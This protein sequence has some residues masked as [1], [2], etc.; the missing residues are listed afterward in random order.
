M[1]AAGRTAPRRKAS[2]GDTDGK[3]RP[4]SEVTTMALSSA[5]NRDDFAGI[6]ITPLVD[7][8]LVLLILFMISAPLLMQKLELPLANG[9]HPPGAQ[10]IKLSL[11]ID[12]GGVVSLDGRALSKAQLQGILAM[13]ASRG[14][15]P[16]L[17]LDASA[18]APYQSVAEV[19]SLAKNLGLERI[20][21]AQR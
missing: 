2:A 7:V 11:G 19:L 3:G 8:M 20:E 6:N 9:S 12:S 14:E 17:S 16:M 18:D 10:P 5:S 13:E 21:L 15:R 1:L 4:R